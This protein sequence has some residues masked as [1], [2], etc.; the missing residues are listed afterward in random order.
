VLRKLRIV[1]ITNP[2]AAFAVFMM[3]VSTATCH[4]L[5]RSGRAG[6]WAAWFWSRFL[7]LVSGVKLDAKGQENVPRENG[8]VLVSNHLS[9][10]DI[11]ILMLSL[12]VVFLFMAKESLFNFPF[13]GWNLKG[14]GHIPVNREDKR[15]A[16]K[17]LA[18]ARRKVQAGKS[19]LIFAEGSRSHGGEMRKFKS[20]AAHLAIKTGATVVPIGIRG[21]AEALPRGT[22]QVR[23]ARI[24]VRI[25]EPL[26]A[27]DFD[28][29]EDLTAVLQGRIRKLTGE[30]VM[31]EGAS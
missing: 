25:G 9:M 27:T 30:D 15:S 13:I 14:G 12:P 20:G 2:L 28:G 17:A 11:P 16:V 21:S 22:I 23:P 24:R 1:L 29:A 3:G 26:R 18:E 5:D 19:V 6:H 4:F 10:M 31:E 7:I 8:L